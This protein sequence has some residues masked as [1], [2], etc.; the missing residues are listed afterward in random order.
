MPSSTYITK[1]FEI[2]TG[3]DAIQQYIDSNVGRKVELVPERIGSASLAVGAGESREGPKTLTQTVYSEPRIDRGLQ[4]RLFRGI[5]RLL[6]RQ[7]LKRLVVFERLFRPVA[8]ITPV[9]TQVRDTLKNEGIEAVSCSAGRPVHFEG[10]QPFADKLAISRLNEAYSLTGFEK[11]RFVEE[12]IAASI[13]YLHQ[14]PQNRAASVLTTDFGGGTLD[15]SVLHRSEQ[16]TYNV[17]ATHG[18]AIGGDHIDQKMFEHMLFPLLGQGERWLRE[19]HDKTIFTP[20]PFEQYAGP[21]LN[22]GIT[23]SLNQ[24][25]Y[26]A[27]IYDCLARAKGLS[28]RKFQRLLRYIQYNMSYQ[29][30][31]SLSD[32]KTELSSVE[33]GQLD[34]P[35]IDLNIALSRS[36][37]EEMLGDF[38]R[39]VDQATMETLQLANL[40]SDEIDIV[41]CTGG[42]SLIPAYRQTLERRFPSKLVD[43]DPFGSVAAGLAIANQKNY[44][45]G[46][47]N[48]PG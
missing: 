7:D 8:L 13:S 44:D 18:V 48:V 28:H 31:A 21:L 39:R 29:V 43:L 34:V 47:H 30:F 5:K 19:G 40:R 33:A 22:W 36:E 12:P 14:H 9:L 46:T 11:V 10:E 15:F 37:F 41:L 23:Y 4:G 27:P 20:F 16:G 35:E 1:S 3:L 42:S 24:N 38:L 25:R 32:L 2:S 26:T 45:A 17:I 6:G